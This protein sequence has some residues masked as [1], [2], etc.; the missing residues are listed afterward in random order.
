MSE[1]APTYS[2]NPLLDGIEH[3]G[4]W[5]HVAEMA[6]VDDLP[7]F[8]VVANNVKA[9]APTIVAQV[10]AVVADVVSLKTLIAAIAVAAVAKGVNVTADAGVL[11]ALEAAVPTFE[12]IAADVQTLTTTVSQDIA[13]DVEELG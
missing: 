11:A 12:K 1:Q 5:L 2:S 9:Q 10:Q 7:K 8:I 4:H 3:V 6:V 13:T